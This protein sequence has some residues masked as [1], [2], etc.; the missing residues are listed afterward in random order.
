MT[1]FG[2]A[3]GLIASASDDFIEVNRKQIEEMLGMKLPEDERARDILG[4]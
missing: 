4:S 3:I 1:E 2:K